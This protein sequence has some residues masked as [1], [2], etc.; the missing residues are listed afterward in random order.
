M[1]TALCIF[2]D[3]FWLWIDADNIHGPGCNTKTESMWQLWGTG[4]QRDSKE[5]LKSSGGSG[6]KEYSVI[7]LGR[8]GSCLGEIFQVG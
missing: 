8:N 3:L 1:L 7:R 4:G 2:N 5:E 6:A